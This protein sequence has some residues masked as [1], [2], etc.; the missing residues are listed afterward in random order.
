MSGRIKIVDV[1]EVDEQLSKL[2]Q[3]VEQDGAIIRIM[4]SGFPVAILKREDND[5]D[6]AEARKEAMKEM[7][8]LHRSGLKLGLGPFKRNNHY[9]RC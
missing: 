5:P 9:D 1:T 8:R 6:V 4:R 2:I 7:E 3:E